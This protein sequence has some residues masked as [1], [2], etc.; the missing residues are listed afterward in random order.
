[1]G[2]VMYGS[3]AVRSLSLQLDPE[4][5]QDHDMIVVLFSA[6]QLYLDGYWSSGNQRL[7]RRAILMDLFNLTSFQR[8][9]Y[10]YPSQSVYLLIKG[11]SPT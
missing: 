4:Q 11:Y 9:R 7:L 6:I 5:G 2:H 8:T 1:M 10:Q 3:H